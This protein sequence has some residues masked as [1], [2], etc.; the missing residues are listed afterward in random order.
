MTLPLYSVVTVPAAVWNGSH[1]A[2]VSGYVFDER[3]AILLQLNV[4]KLNI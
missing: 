1:N 2:P 3:S 4:Y